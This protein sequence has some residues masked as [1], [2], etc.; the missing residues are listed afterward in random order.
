MAQANIKAVIT[1]EDRGSAVLGN[2]SNNVENAGSKIARVG[3]MA[4]A[5][6]VA[7]AVAAT[8]FAVKSAADFEQT[9][10]GLE[11]MLGSAD[12]ARNLL[13]K[14]SKFAADTP[15]Q[16][17]ELAQSTRMLVA[18]G[19]SAEDA[20]KG[21]QTLGDV[22]AAVGANITDLSYLYGTLRAQGRAYTV[23]I[24]Q[25]ATRGIPIYEYL[26]KVLGVDAQKVSELVEAGK[27]G[28]PEVEKAFKMMTAE[29]GQFHGTMEKQSKSLAGLWSTFSDN[30]GQAGRELVGISQTGDVVK[31]SLFDKL[32][33]GLSEVIKVLPGLI[34]DFKYF[35]GEVV[36]FMIPIVNSIIDFGKQT[37][38][39]L[40]PKLMTLWNTI[41]TKLMPVMTSLWHKVIEPLIPVIGTALVV[42]IGAVVDI[43]NILITG[44]SW[45]YT[46]LE[47]GNPIIWT[48]AGAFGGLAAA[49]AFNAIFNALTIGFNVLTLITIPSIMAS[50]GALQ[51]LITMPM[52]M[53]AI[54]VGAAIASIVLVIA[55]TYELIATLKDVGD[56]IEKTK[57]EGD[58]T[59]ARIKKLHD[60]GKISTERLN[61]YLK[62]T[63]DT[64][65]KTSNDMYTGFFGPM[66]KS[67]DSLFANISGTKAKFKGTG[68]G[69]FATGGFTGRGGTNEV[70][71]LVHKGEYVLP[72]SAVDQT[73]GM[74]KLNM[75]NQS[76]TTINVTFSGIFTGSEIEMRKLADKVF[77]ARQDAMNMNGQMA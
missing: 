19:F 22:S 63:K 11:N 4:A 29:G 14:I 5:A 45:L 18:F 43:A 65:D 60:E 40:T 31:G 3:K 41:S 54:A 44:I 25:F 15:F 55:K 20:Y 34:K 8:T 62:N 70:A 26:G 64:A 50:I 76:G 12:K 36:K 52:V 28:F 32:R 58:K 67:L 47:K 46:E 27:V 30:I 16:F 72:K 38:E 17:P 69:G 48:L 59:D 23:D 2:F 73:T 6:F 53:P 51:S 75:R 21:M 66:N 13:G 49:M 24:K 68:F 74:P 37:A 71:G 77:N 42:A 33:I 1:A 9:R 39:Y 61:T 57:K 10:I 56:S 7:A 35:S